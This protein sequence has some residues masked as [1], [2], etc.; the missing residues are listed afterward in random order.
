MFLLQVRDLQK[1]NGERIA[2]NA[3]S[4]EMM[5]HQKIAIAGET[6]S[7]KTTLLKMIGG[8]VQPDAGEVIF[9]G[10]RVEGPLER[11]IPGHESIAYLSQHF[12][13]RNNYWVYE[14]LEMANKI[15]QEEA[16][17]LFKVCQIEHLMHRRTNELSGGEKQ[18]IVLA[19]QLIKK[20]KLLLLDEPFSNLNAIHEQT[21]KE[22]IHDVSEH[23]NTSSIMVSH[24]GKDVLSW[25]DLII[26]IKDGEIVQQATPSVIYHQPA[27]AYCAGL[28]GAF[29]AISYEEQ[30]LFL[31][32]DIIKHQ[33]L[34]L[35]PEQLQLLHESS[36][37]I[38]VTVEKVFFEG[39]HYMVQVRNQSLLLQTRTQLDLNVGEKL[40][41][42]PAINKPHFLND[43]N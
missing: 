8:F 36:N 31:Q 35:R 16:T 39:A 42:K 9:E 5:R 2:V 40:F 18:R 43:I 23:F 17:Q 24:D 13:L 12:E 20:P 28:F 22:V 10:K 33:P 38:P 26:V 14:L 25:A 34:M 37:N 21:I 19:M 11:L 41:I 1:K 30:H 15:P 27:N 6:G 3:V 29:N 32:N 7:G 4:F